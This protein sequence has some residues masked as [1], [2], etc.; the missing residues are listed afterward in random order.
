MK[1]NVFFSKNNE[2]LSFLKE[3]FQLD[4][5]DIKDN[6]LVLS[7]IKGLVHLK[8]KNSFNKI[9]GFW[10]EFLFDKTVEG[11]DFYNK[12]ISTVHRDQ[13]DDNVFY[14]KDGLK[15]KEL[16]EGWFNKYKFLEEENNE[17]LW[18][19]FF[20]EIKSHLKEKRFDVVFYGSLVFLRYNP[21]YLKRYNRF[22]IFEELAYHYEEVG[23]IGKAVK[24]LKVHLKL[25]PDSVE[26]YLNMTSFYIINEMEEIAI[27]LCKEA[28][29]KHP[30]NKYL[31][32]NMVLA[33]SNLGNYDY[34][35]E[36]IKKA[37]KKQPDNP[38]FWK[39][40]GDLSYEIEQNK[41][42]I[43]C[44]QKALTK[45]KDKN[46]DDFTV[47]LYHGIASAY[48]EED[49]FKE[50][51]KYYKKVLKYYPADSY[52]L[53]SLS[54]IYLNNLKDLKVALH[55]GKILIEIAPENG[56]GQ[57]QLGTIYLQ[58][59]NYEKAKWHLYKARRML[60]YYE[61]VLEAI[62][63]LKQFNKVIKL[64]DSV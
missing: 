17:A 13:I 45:L 57:Y 4:D 31:V 55:Y 24:C 26:P 43:D 25:Q 23:N 34:A 11:K 33:L 38:F 27:K 42:A 30:Q 2:R 18:D 20:K 16:Q 49:N 50:A 1:L 14:P 19:I 15:Y 36:F 5:I 53:L 51:V 6:K 47:D 61:P 46:N 40:M 32:S 37:I 28:L 7:G 54:Q 8:L 44:Y 9:P 3:Q 39:M 10:L 52:V 22:Y 60:P 58:M 63:Y 64:H 21:F 41:E 48:Y 29:K 59:E 62:Q 35:V 12:I 56:Y